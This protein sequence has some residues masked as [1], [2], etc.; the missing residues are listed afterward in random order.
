MENCVRRIAACKCVV[1]RSVHAVAIVAAAGYSNRESR[2]EAAPRPLELLIR[3][4]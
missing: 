4:N 1:V 2:E 3:L